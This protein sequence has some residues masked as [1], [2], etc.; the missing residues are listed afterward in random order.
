MPDIDDSGRLVSSRSRNKFYA[1]SDKINVFLV[2]FV[3][4]VIGTLNKTIKAL[5]DLLQK[6]TGADNKEEATE[7]AISIMSQ[8]PHCSSQERDNGE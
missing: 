4:D 8:N 7:K 5:I 2:G 1:N 6:K 3:K